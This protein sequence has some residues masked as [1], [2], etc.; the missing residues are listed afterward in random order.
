MQL[1]ENL[2]SLN[3]KFNAWIAKMQKPDMEQKTT[4]YRL[5]AV[6]QKAGLGIRQSLVSLLQGQ[7]NKGMETAV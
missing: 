7:Q 3:E 5:L 1:S 4:F 2:S 6:S